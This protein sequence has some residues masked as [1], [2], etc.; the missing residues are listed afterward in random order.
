MRTWI[1]VAL[2]AICS[3]LAAPASAFQE[4]ETRVGWRGKSYLLERL[5]DEFP[6][7][8]R[9]TVEAWSP[10][11][12]RTGYRMDLDQSSRV[13]VITT[14]TSGRAGSELELVERTGE[15]F[16]ELLP[17]PP[18]L[19]I[20]ARPTPQEAEIDSDP[21][22]IPEDP[23]ETPPGLGAPVPAP[24]RTAAR[25]PTYTW[26]AGAIEP[27]T[28]TAVMLVLHDEKDY[29]DVLAFL[30]QQQ[31]YLQAWVAG[32]QVRI[33]FA[34]EL[35]LCGAYVENASGQE[36]WDPDN[37]LVH[38]V[39]RL[40]MLRRFGQQPYW[41]SVGLSWHAELSVRRTIYCFPYRNG[42]VGIGEHGGWAAAL[43]SAFKGRKS[44]PLEMSEFADWRP[45]TYEDQKAMLAWG[46]VDFLANEHA[47]SCSALLE[48]LRIFR[49]QDNRQSTGEN[50]WQRRLDYE[51]PADTQHSLFA[52]HVGE[53]FLEEASDYWRNGGT[54][55]AKSGRSK[56]RRR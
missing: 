12:A 40:L 37:E 18:A 45:G 20:A 6:D 55:T 26:G 35:P 28:Q 7:Q 8:A 52:R 51:I 54:T 31:P 50:S 24:P 47:S 56:N 29:A 11:V 4:A 22:E 33:G 38:R 43:R 32:A 41:L 27:D 19:T 44:N 49:D 39:M 46:L 25:E 9:A 13:L 42:F 15:L 53:G 23:E 16:D 10:W 21:D 2:A 17:A 36:E 48:D 34:I 14:H 5:P 1:P 30:A 3:G